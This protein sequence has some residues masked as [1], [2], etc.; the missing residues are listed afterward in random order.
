MIGKKVKVT[1]D[2]KIYEGLFLGALVSHKS[3]V[4]IE[5]NGKQKTMSFDN[6]E[7]IEE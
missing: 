2:N 5:M 1:K 4:I 3:V 6:I 7:I